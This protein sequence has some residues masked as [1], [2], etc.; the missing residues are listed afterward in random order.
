MATQGREDQ[1]SVVG[2]GRKQLDLGD[3]SEMESTGFGNS[4]DVGDERGEPG[5]MLRGWWCHPL[6][7]LMGEGPRLG[8]MVWDTQ[9]EVLE[10][11]YSDDF[12]NC[13]Q[14]L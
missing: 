10:G 3:I 2:G 12:S 11:H 6:G 7:M 14:A 13:P 8:S 9:N 5:R 1:N 4:M